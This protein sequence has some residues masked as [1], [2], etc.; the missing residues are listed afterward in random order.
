MNGDHWL[1]YMNQQDPVGATLPQNMLT[2]VSRRRH[3]PDQTMEILMTELDQD[4][5]QRFYNNNRQVD[6]HAA[7]KDL[8]TALGIDQLFPSKLGG[9]CATKLDAYLFEPCGY[10]LNLIAQEDR[11]ATI[12][13]TPEPDCSYAS[14]ETNASFGAGSEGPRLGVQQMVA[15]VLDIFRPKRFSLTLFVSREEDE[16]ETSGEQGF[17]LL[18]KG[19]FPVGYK[20]IDKITYEFEDYDLL[21]VYLNP[22]KS[23]HIVLMRTLE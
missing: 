5:C 19:K 18:H 9:P 14:F 17:A 1:L 10:S 13:V 8:S 3:T 11:Y 7:G 20:R 12:H 22:L 6:A 16:P 15:R 21:C 2:P 23:K 4:S